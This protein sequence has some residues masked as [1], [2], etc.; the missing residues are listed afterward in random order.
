MNPNAVQAIKAAAISFFRFTGSLSLLAG[1][2]A[3][4]YGLLDF[5]RDDYM[6]QGLVWMIVGATLL[7]FSGL[8][9]RP[10]SH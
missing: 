6:A 9:P 8:V 7:V 10:D 1:V 4:T 5:Q 2:A 3:A